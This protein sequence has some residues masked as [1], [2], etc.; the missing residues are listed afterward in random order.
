MNAKRNTRKPDQKSPLKGMAKR[1]LVAGGPLGVKSS[2]LTLSVR[3]LSIPETGIHLSI[4]ADGGKRRWR[5]MLNEFVR[6]LDE[7]GQTAV[8]TIL[9]EEPLGS[10]WVIAHRIAMKVA[11]T[12]I[13]AAIDASLV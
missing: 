9:F 12:R 11:E 2:D 5:A 13:D 3:S 6:P 10:E 7:G 4:V 1:I 8:S